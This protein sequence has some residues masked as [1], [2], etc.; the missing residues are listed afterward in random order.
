L[1]RHRGC[2]M[3]LYNKRPKALRNVNCSLTPTAQTD[4]MVPIF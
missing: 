2:D 3:L 1:C 4:P